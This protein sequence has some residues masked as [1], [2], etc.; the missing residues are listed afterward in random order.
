MSEQ[1]RKR[2][3]KSSRYRRLRHQKQAV[4]P[5]V[6]TL[7]L[8]LIAVAAA[9]A[10]YLWLVSF[11]G[12]VTGKIGSPNSQC[13]L[14]IGGST[15][16]YPLTQLAIK[17]FEQ[18]NS[19]VSV[20]AQQG[21]ST[22]GVLSLCQGQGVDIAASSSYQL[23]P[24]LLADGCPQ[25]IVQTTVGLDAVGFV[26]ANNN[27]VVTGLGSLA[28]PQYEAAAAAAT[29]T[30]TI[31]LADTTTPGLFAGGD[32]IAVTATGFG[33]VDLVQFT[34]AGAAGTAP[35]CPV[36]GAAPA[37]MPGASP[38]T[39]N[40]AAPAGNGAIDTVA[41]ADTSTPAVGTATGTYQT[42]FTSS[43]AATGSGLAGGV[44]NFGTGLSE[45]MF[46]FNVSVGDAIYSVASSTV[47]IAPATV[48][49][50]SNWPAFLGTFPGQGTAPT[51]ASIPF[52]TNCVFAGTSGHPAPESKLAGSVPCATVAAATNHIKVHDRQDNSGTEDGFATKLLGW[53]CGSDHQLET[54]NIIV[55][56]D[57]GNP[58][59]QAA[60]SADANALGFLSFGF[61]T[62]PGS[63]V[64]FAGYLGN[65]SNLQ[66]GHLGVQ[67]AAQTPSVT[68][69]KA[70]YYATSSTLPN[71][72]YAGWRVLEY[73]T[74]G[75]P[76]GEA[77]S[78]ITYVLG[79]EVNQQLCKTNGFVSL[80]Q[81]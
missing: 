56:H 80:Y 57:I 55:T 58:G 33:T 44:V 3:E 63:G 17:Q 14:Q 12:G 11:Q 81:S 7:I 69:T 31:L 70:G 51:W 35:A 30:G 66:A 40:I 22:A 34:Y 48:Y 73:L 29:G 62:A 5:V 6:A 10:L 21:G 36:S 13:T 64:A 79:A 8:I 77:N 43:A 74:I 78:F 32:N 38:Y 46:S 52:P 2:T 9:A 25:N 60:V 20:C 1:S 26:A 67:S 23:S 39:C 18:N 4:S 47:P 37:V 45:Q 49:T 54:C 42:Q 27:P 28:I 71:T 65:P 50:S 61:A 24:T 53:T 68:N 19:G 59:V 16:V 75:Q 76:T 72:V 41:I 15:T